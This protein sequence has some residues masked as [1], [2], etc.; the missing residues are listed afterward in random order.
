MVNQHYSG[1]N[2][3]ISPFLQPEN[4]HRFALNAIQ[5]A[6]DGNGYTIQ[7][8]PGNELCTDLNI[9]HATYISNNEQLIFT[10][11][12]IGILNKD[13]NY[14][15]LVNDNCLDINFPIQSE[16]RVRSGCERVVY[17]VDNMNPDRFINIDNLDIHKSDDEFDCNKFNIQSNVNTACFKLNSINGSLDQ[18]NYAIQI[19]YLD[20]DNNIKYRSQISRPIY[21]EQA[22][23]IKIN[24]TN[25]D[26]SFPY[27]R[28]NLITTNDAIP[29]AYQDQNILQTETSLEYDITDL[30][31]FIEIDYT[32]TLQPIFNIRSSK[33]IEQVQDRLV[34]ANTKQDSRDYSTYQKLASKIETFYRLDNNSTSTFIPNE[35]YARGIVYIHTDGSL[36]P[37]F[38][39]P[40]RCADVYNTDC[41]T[42]Q[43]LVIFGANKPFRVI[44][45]L[46]GELIT[47]EGELTSINPEITILETCSSDVI[48]DVSIAYSGIGIVDYRIDYST[49][50]TTCSNPLEQVYKDGE[51]FNFFEL[52]N[53]YCPISSN[54]GYMGYWHCNNDYT[55]PPNLCNDEDYWGI[56]SCGNDLINTSVRHHV[57]PIVALGQSIQIESSN[58]EYPDDVVGHYFVYKSMNRVQDS[59]ILGKLRVD[60]DNEIFIYHDTDNNSNWNYFISPRSLNGQLLE[61]DLF[62]S[63]SV[64]YTKELQEREYKSNPDI[65]IGVRELIAE[66][67]TEVNQ[68]IEVESTSY[69]RPAETN[70]TVDNKELVNLSL[71][72]PVQIIEAQVDPLNSNRNSGYTDQLYYAQII[73]TNSSLCDLF[74]IRYSRYDN[75]TDNYITNT[76]DGFINNFKYLNTTISNIQEQQL[77]DYLTRLVGVTVAQA[78][79]ASSILTKNVGSAIGGIVEYINTEIQFVNNVIRELRDQRYEG[80]QNNTDGDFT[81]SNA[82]GTFF[83]GEYYFANEYLTGFFTH[84]TIN[85][86]REDLDIECGNYYNEDDTNT[87]LEYLESKL[88]DYDEE[89]DE[90]I[91]KAF[92][93]LEYYIY[94]QDMSITSYNQYIPLPRQYKY[95]SECIN[96]QPYRIYFSPRSFVEEISDSYLELFVNDYID[97]PSNRGEI[98]ALKYKNNQLLVH[99][100]ESTFVL[101]PYPQLIATDQDNAYIKTD[102][103]FS[104][105]AS[106]IIQNDIGYGGLQFSDARINTE[107]GY[108]WVDTNAGEIINFSNSLNEISKVGLEQWYKE[109]L[110]NTSFN[111]CTYDPRFDRFILFSDL[112]TISYSYKNNSW[113][114]YHSYIQD[115]SFYNTTHFFTTNSN[116]TYK[117]LHKNNYHNFNGIQYP[118]V[119][120]FVH[121]NPLTEV[122]HTTHWYC[123][124]EESNDKLLPVHK[125]YDQAVIYN[126]CQS[127]GLMNLNSYH[128]DPY[129]DSFGNII[130]TD[131]NHKLSG[132]FDCSNNKDVYNN[133]FPIITSDK[134][135][136]NTDDKSYYNKGYLSDKF[137]IIRLISNTDY[138]ITHYLTKTNTLNSIR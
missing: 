26:T 133:I 105:P 125:S 20:E 115:Y 137:H 62:I 27:I 75:C 5:E 45:R 55:N 123:T 84:N 48:S 107:N 91:P 47:F 49:L 36:S 67:S 89:N 14:T 16:F 29:I 83:G 74:N 101:K 10:E 96:N 56:D 131:F 35:V 97:I 118:F 41:N 9:K 79:I 65:F 108:T 53:T 63:H 34:R 95:C 119:I 129:Y 6:F 99:T 93:C 106:E 30:T 72:L 87:L 59:G 52:N 23:G 117:H 78:T 71:N 1:I 113:T 92:P 25:V 114:S 28:F 57:M 103:F 50:N 132:L 77:D 24:L 69:L 124:L 122:F 85:Y 31:N 43:S 70:R 11:N 66:N 120:E 98:I 39:I 76:G 58:I 46:N 40:G 4:T 104:I 51:Q 42:T 90:Y 128:S 80:F 18:S 134:E 111:H 121:T 109:N 130:I 110:P 94:D 112:F 138:R 126:S 17:W 2:K 15:E 136:I 32:Q 64:N 116:K 33:A 37:V 60:N 88:L 22:K 21:L 82:L 44:Y 12:T 38:H 54:K 19:E 8:E 100:E 61:G 73:N 7:S 81:G 86:I 102:D 127:T 13:C 135:F 68:L 3:D